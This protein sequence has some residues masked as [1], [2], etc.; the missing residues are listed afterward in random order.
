MSYM[1][2]ERIVLLAPSSDLL[3]T[4]E[5]GDEIWIFLGGSVE[6]PSFR[7]EFGEE[8]RVLG[9][10]ER[11]GG[12]GGDVVLFDPRVGESRKT[13]GE[14]FHAR[15]KEGGEVGRRRREL[16]MEEGLLSVRFDD[17]DSEPRSMLVERRGRKRERERRERKGGG[18]V[19]RCR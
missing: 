17:R 12:V 18:G 9:R 7:E 19:C 11:P 6:P 16:P 13:G 5:T 15:R 14:H 10:R 4:Q 8:A 3:A 1:L 2:L